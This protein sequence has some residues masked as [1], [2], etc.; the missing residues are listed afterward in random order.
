MGRFFVL[1]E[2]MSTRGSPLEAN[3]RW[4]CIGGLAMWYFYHSDRNGGNADEEKECSR[5]DFL[6]IAGVA[7]GVVLVGMT[8]SAGFLLRSSSSKPLGWRDSSG[9]NCTGVYKKDG[10]PC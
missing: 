9:P 1:T 2:H 5:R 3:Q 8:P 7:G 6:K 4:P 10:N